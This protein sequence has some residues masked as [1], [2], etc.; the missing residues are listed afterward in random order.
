MSIAGQM[1]RPLH[2][3]EQ[4]GRIA[5]ACEVEHQDHADRRDA[6]A[7]PDEHA[8]PGREALVHE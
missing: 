2:L 4:A 3:P 6:D 1:R 5:L 7:G 8:P